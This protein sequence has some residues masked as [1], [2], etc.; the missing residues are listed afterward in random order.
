M[1][2]CDFLNCVVDGKRKSGL[3]DEV[4]QKFIMVW[5]QEIMLS[6]EKKVGDESRLLTIIYVE[7]CNMLQLSHW[8]PFANWNFIYHR[9]TLPN[10]IYQNIL[11]VFFVVKFLHGKN[12][13]IATLIAVYN[14]NVTSLMA[15]PHHN[16]YTIHNNDWIHHPTSRR[17]FAVVN[18]LWAAGITSDHISLNE[19]TFC[20]PIMKATWCTWRFLKL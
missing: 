12:S 6:G 5:G 4:E 15:P 20:L 8:P 14:C 9:F 1:T 17:S 2:S 10:P 16:V 11:M 18:K 13:T 19:I 3:G 7:F